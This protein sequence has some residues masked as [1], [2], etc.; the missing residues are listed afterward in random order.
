MGDEEE[1]KKKMK[2]KKVLNQESGTRA[3]KTYILGYSRLVNV[4]VCVCVGDF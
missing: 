4:C 1:G 3:E 2:K